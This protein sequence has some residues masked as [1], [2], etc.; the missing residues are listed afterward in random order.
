MTFRSLLLLVVAAAIA[1]WLAIRLPDLVDL[2]LRGYG[3]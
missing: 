3:Y 1:T 2:A